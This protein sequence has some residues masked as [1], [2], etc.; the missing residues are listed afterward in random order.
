MLSLHC[1]CIQAQ[2]ECDILQEFVVNK[3][4]GDIIHSLEN[5]QNLTTCQSYF[6]AIAFAKTG[7][8]EESSSIYDELINTLEAKEDL[9]PDIYY[10]KSMNDLRLGSYQSMETMAQNA[11]QACLDIF[12]QDTSLYT[13]ILNTLGYAQKLNGSYFQSVKTYEKAKSLKEKR[14]EEDIQYSRILNNLGESYRILNQFDKAESNLLRSLTLKGKLRGEKSIDYSKSLYNLTVLYQATNR[15]EEALKHINASLEILTLDLEKNKRQETKCLQLKVSLLE[16]Q[17]NLDEALSLAKIVETR[18]IEAGQELSSA[19]A[20]LQLTLAGLESKNKN[21]TAA[22]QHYD[23]AADLF[24]KVHGNDHPYY[25]IS[26]RSAINA[27]LDQKEFAGLLPL[28]E[29]SNS[30]LNKKFGKKHIEYLKGL[31]TLFRFYNLNKKFDQGIGV[32]DNLQDPLFDYMKSSAR[33]LSNKEMA[34]NIQFY[35]QY[36]RQLLYLNL[37]ASN[38]DGVCEIAFQSSLFLKGYLMQNLI[39]EREAIKSSKE[40]TELSTELASIK[41]QIGEEIVLVDPNKEKLDNLSYEESK[42]NSRI[43][44]MIGR[45]QSEESYNW[46]D[47]QFELEDDEVAIDFV[48]LIDFD[49][50][51]ENYGAFLIKPYADEP[52]FIPLFKENKITDSFEGIKNPLS[53]IKDLYDYN[54][55]S[56]IVEKDSISLYDYLWKPLEAELKNINKISYCADG[57]IH[58]L[59]LQAI[60]IDIENTLTDKYEFLR[61][62]SFNSLFEEP[63]STDNENINAL[64]IGGVEYGSSSADNN[65]NRNSRGNWSELPWTLKEIEEIESTITK[66]KHSVVKYTADN[67]QEKNIKQAINGGDQYQIIHCATH[68]FFEDRLVM[69]VSGSTYNDNN[70]WNMSNSGL[71]LAGAN[72]ATSTEDNLW[73]AYEISQLDLS[74]TKL[75]VLSA[76]ETGLGQVYENEGVYGLQ[77]AF[78]IAGVDYVI[79]SLWEVPDRETK[80]FMTLLY[81]NYISLNQNIIKAFD[82][83]QK[84]MKERFIDPEKWAGFVLLK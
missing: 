24:K 82:L 57:I 30:I 68:G 34:E 31:Y 33:Y 8:I 29:K 19:F 47:I 32:I 39:K 28:I 65:R 62:C 26:L 22:N 74:H 59:S 54:R 12:G 73:S 25:A 46:R 60:P 66:A 72:A 78:K 7:K 41:K 61:L 18:W 84:A 38:L 10:N 51:K 37:K 63:T 45:L 55:R 56:I 53:I 58:K 49:A 43:N 81:E 27:K 36:H 79:M 42:L 77:R 16:E 23:T 50:E 67:A 40:I 83:T 70:D 13:K 15:I 80:E 76:C 1:L 4:Y 69:E 6:K 75:A 17:Q 48:R 14:F 2:V 64:L 71:V 20:K 9:L 3:N 35:H 11:R 52:S 21:Y 5:Q 44:R